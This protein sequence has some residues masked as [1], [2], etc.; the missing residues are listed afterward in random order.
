MNRQ[1][2]VPIRVKHSSDGSQREITEE[3]KAVVE[4]EP[5]V[6][7]QKAVVD[8]HAVDDAITQRGGEEIP[9]PPRREQK[10]AEALRAELETWRDR[11]LRLQAEMENFR[12][13][14]R[15]LAQ[16]EV[17]ENRA[18]LLR[19]FLTIADDLERALRAGGDEESLR[20]GIQ[21][22]YR[23]LKQLLKQAGAER[24]EAEG[25]PFD[26]EWHEAVATVPHQAA[27]ADR[28][29]VVQVAQ[30]GYRLDGKLLRPAQVVVAT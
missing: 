17:E 7:E 5:A 23:S 11:A 3:E 30:E 21:V 26:P 19:S 9:A 1:V 28:D 18:R 25:Q 16:D 15:R 12:K 20:E 27:D 13:R 4:P 8:H 29:T 6:V 14:Q 22:S 24:I 10:E 2:Q